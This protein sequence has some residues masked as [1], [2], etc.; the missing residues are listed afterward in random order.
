MQGSEWTGFTVHPS[1]FN[2]HLLKKLGSDW[3]AYNQGREVYII[4]N[5]TVGASLAEIA[6]LQV[7]E[8]E[9][10]KIVDVG[11]M[12]RK[13]ILLQQMPFDESFNSQ[14]LSEPVPQPLL[15]LIDVLLEDQA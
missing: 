14:C 9:A 8:E 5:K 10:E 3:S 11:I 6:Q 7:T 1:R 2:E 12:L 13:Y 15:I 4:H